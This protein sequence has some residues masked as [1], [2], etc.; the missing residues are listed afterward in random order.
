MGDNPLPH[1]YDILGLLL[2]VFNGGAGS[3]QCAGDG[4]RDLLQ[5]Q[6]DQGYSAVVAGDA[7][8][9]SECSEKYTTGD[10][11]NDCMSWQ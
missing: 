4:I 7:Y 10:L 8:T 9:S 5:L 2:E 3:L 11:T 6:Q 1:L